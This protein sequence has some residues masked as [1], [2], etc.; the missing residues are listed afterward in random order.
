MKLSERESL[1]KFNYFL[2]FLCLHF[3]RVMSE[4][5]KPA[6]Q[7]S[8]LHEK[9]KEINWSQIRPMWNEW[10]EEKVSHGRYGN[11]TPYLTIKKQLH[12]NQMKLLLQVKP[13]VVLP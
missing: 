10:I 11:E 5:L 2:E 1:P 4:N 6:V 7:N 3:S 12:L 13:R 8:E 9:C